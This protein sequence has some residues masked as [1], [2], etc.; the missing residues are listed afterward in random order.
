MGNLHR[1]MAFGAIALNLP[2]GGLTAT[3]KPQ[4]QKRKI[5]LCGYHHPNDFARLVPEIG[6][7][8]KVCDKNY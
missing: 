3:Q 7:F 6:L 8:S 5:D 2:F 1:A 4:Y